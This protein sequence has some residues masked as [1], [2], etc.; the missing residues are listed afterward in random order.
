MGAMSMHRR[1]WLGELLVA[2]SLCQTGASAQTVTVADIIETVKVVQPDRT[3]RAVDMSP[4]GKHFF[5]VTNHPSL[6]RDRI[7]SVLTLYDTDAVRA[8]AAASE[9]LVP[10]RGREILRVE[11]SPK[12]KFGHG[13]RSGAWTGNGT[14]AFLAELKDEPTQ[15]YSVDVRSGV[16]KPLTHHERP[17]IAF[18]HDARSNTTAYYSTMPDDFP[19]FRERSFVMGAM[20]YILMTHPAAYGEWNWTVQTYVVRGGG[21]ARKVGPPMTYYGPARPRLSPD[22]RFV[23]LAVDEPEGERASLWS[24]EY[25]PHRQRLPLLGVNDPLTDAGAGRTYL[26]RLAFFDTGT[27]R[28]VFD[29]DAPLWSIVRDVSRLVAWSA[30][31]E[32]LWVS[33]IL[34]PLEGGVR[35]A[36]RRGNVYVGELS[37]RTWQLREIASVQAPERDGFASFA[38][39]ELFESE[40]TALRIRISPNRS[41]ELR[42]SRG[43]WT[44]REIVDEER[45]SSG[46]GPELVVKEELNVPPDLFVQIGDGG[47]AR[48]TTLNPR[49]T[50]SALGKIEPFSWTDSD[51]TAW[52][53][54]LL[55]PAGRS[56]DRLP[57]VVQ[58]YGGAPRDTFYLDGPSRIPT[59]FPGR[60][61]ATAG[62]A[63][64]MFPFPKRTEDRREMLSARAGLASAIAKLDAMGVVD[65]DRVGIIGFSDSGRLAHDAITFSTARFR[66]AVISNAWAPT[67]FS[68]MTGAW[69][70]STSNSTGRIERTLDSVPW[71][72]GMRK[73][74]ANDPS[75]N[76]HCIQAALRLEQNDFYGNSYWD[77]YALLRRQHKPVELVI[78][79]RGFHHLVRPGERWDSLQGNVDWFRFWLKGEEDADPSK[80]EQYQR[81]R[82]MRGRKPL[83]APDST[84]PAR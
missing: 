48:V 47:Y 68:L 70:A 80:A 29:M 72:E 27:G 65:P 35:G 58:T 52:S 26:T 69:G 19:V 64:L 61:L 17:V 4:D 81:W 53:G 57:L 32:R 54:G 56:S 31:G 33:G 34:L 51:G 20:T 16:V 55:L 71:G 41:L 12:W 21:A 22:G 24:R 50:P 83:S 1:L 10:P 28:K 42:E 45:R 38:E 23:A 30:D 62:M 43:A 36:E 82:E 8:F 74:V 2:A 49:L 66:A 18:D 5:M 40:P 79:P 84:C 46:A 76:T 67:Y 73:W 7:D 3:R 37:T 78:T 15:A 14:I 59:S 60:A 25:V 6:A 39:I 44:R 9:R 13:I 11:S 75:F 63:V 77:V